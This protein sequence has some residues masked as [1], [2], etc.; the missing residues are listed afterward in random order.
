M[1]AMTPLSYR[2]A[3]RESD[4]VRTRAAASFD[5]SSLPRAVRGGL[6]LMQFAYYVDLRSTGGALSG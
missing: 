4:H 3:I 6:S 2:V 5:T 1:S